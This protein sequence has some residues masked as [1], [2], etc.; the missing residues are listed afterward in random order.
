VQIIGNGL[1]IVFINGLT[2]NFKIHHTTITP[3]SGLM[4]II[5]AM[6]I[7]IALLSVVQGRETIKIFNQILMEYGRAER[8][9]TNGI[10]M[11][12]KSLKMKAH[13]S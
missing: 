11:E 3:D 10:R 6:K 7:F 13:K 1:F 4:V 12:R 5:G 2:T 8:G 9:E